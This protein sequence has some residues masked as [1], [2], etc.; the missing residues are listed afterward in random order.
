MNVHAGL[1]NWLILIGGCPIPVGGDSDHFGR[2]HPSSSG[3]GFLIPGQHYIKARAFF[4]PG[5]PPAVWDQRDI[6]M[7]L[8]IGDRFLLVG[9]PFKTIQKG[10][11]MLRQTHIYIYIYGCGSKP[12][13]PFWGS[14]PP[15]SVY[16]S[17]DCDVH[18][19]YGILTHGH[20]YIY[21]YT[22]TSFIFISPEPGKSQ[23]NP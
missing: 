23:I 2:E 1:I 17:R 13:V 9:F 18:W 22:H 21:I 5:T 19:G 15:S 14:A 12:M 7:L 11:R 16:F 4:F 8:D 3:T 10:S 20:I 6:Q